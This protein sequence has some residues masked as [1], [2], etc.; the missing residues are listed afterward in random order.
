MKRHALKMFALLALPMLLVTSRAMADDA[1]VRKE[2]ETQ[3]NALAQAAQSLDA[4]AVTNIHAAD[5]KHVD[6]LG[7]ERT[8]EEWMG[9]MRTRLEGVQGLMIAPKINDLTVDGDKAMPTIAVKMTGTVMQDGK[10]LPME[11]TEVFRDTWVKGADGWKRKIARLVMQDMR[12]DKKPVRPMLTPEADEVRK[13]LQPVYDGLG[14]I[15]VKRDW[16]AMEKGI[17]ENVVMTDASGKPLNRKEVVERVKEGAKNLS[18]PIMTVTIRLVGVEG[19]TAK[20][21]RQMTVL[22][23]VT[24]PTGKSRL[25]YVNYT[26]DTYTKAEKGWAM[27]SSEELYSEGY[28]DGKPVPLAAFGG[29]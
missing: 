14:D 2:I 25:R 27:K 15:Y 18:D 7:K 22:G 29:K 9:A 4:Q 23:D 24:L 11:T 3:I 1:A 5:F 12:I 19:M 17:G 21:V 20:V 28:L 8:L 13:L 16:A 6:L 26:R 10:S